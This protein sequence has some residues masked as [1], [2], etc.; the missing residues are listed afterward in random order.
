MLQNSFILP[1]R[2][3][4]LSSLDVGIFD[5]MVWSIRQVVWLLLLPGLGRTA[6]VTYTIPSAPPSS[7]A[8]LDPAPVGIS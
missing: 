8:E 5:S 1:L 3:S 2:V 6:T 4:I 7:A